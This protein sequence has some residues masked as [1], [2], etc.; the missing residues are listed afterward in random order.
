MKKLRLYHVYTERLTRNWDVREFKGLPAAIAYYE[1]VIQNADIIHAKL[2]RPTGSRPVIREY[3][4]QADKI[5]TVNESQFLL[6]I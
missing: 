3:K 6:T 5:N 4:K 2:Y 1:A